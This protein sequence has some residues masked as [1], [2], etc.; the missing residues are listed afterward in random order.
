[1]RKRIGQAPTAGEQKQQKPCR[2]SS[3]SGTDLENYTVGRGPM[4]NRKEL[5]GF[6]ILDTE[7]FERHLLY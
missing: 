2:T 6:P 3:D 7:V 4:W 1:M 5:T